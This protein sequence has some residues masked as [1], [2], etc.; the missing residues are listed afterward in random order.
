M[1][2][3]HDPRTGAPPREVHVSEPQKKSKWWLWLLPL[4]AVLA[5]L[6]ALSQCS[7]DREEAPVTNETVVNE[8]AVAPAPTVAPATAAVAAPAV[9]SGL[10]AYLASNEPLPRTFVFERLNFDTGSSTLR[11]ADRDEVSSIAAALKQHPNARVRLHGY[12]DARGAEGANAQLGQARAD[13][14]KAA[15]VE[16]GVDAGRIETA[17][18]GEAQPAETNATTSGQA[19]N[20]RT[21]LVVLQR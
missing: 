12:A 2:N 9:L 10:G 21:E 20:R 3:D 15:L 17:S 4:L 11:P 7:D 16:Q 13:G 8:P 18:G 5:L 1:A 14:V 19:E 6:F